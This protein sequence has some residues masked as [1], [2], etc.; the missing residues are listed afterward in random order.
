MSGAF[1][2]A[3]DAFE[4][5][6]EDLDLREGLS[7]LGDLAALGRRAALLAAAGAVW[8]RRLGPLLEGGEVQTLLGVGSRQAV[9]DLAKRGRLLALRT[10]GGRKLY[11]A[12]Q[13]AEN[14]RPYPDLASVLET[15]AGVVES[16]YTT[17]S[18][19]VSPNTDLAGETPFERLRSGRGIEE[20]LEAARRAAARLAR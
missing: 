13:F 9:S 5:T 14:G 20:L 15:F 4:K 18:W 6:L 1:A 19:L 3:A 7:G 16:T 11:P 10:S 2:I 17:A 8:R 12:F